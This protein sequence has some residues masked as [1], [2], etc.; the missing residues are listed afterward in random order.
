MATCEKTISFNVTDCT[1]SR[2][3]KL[4]V[5]ANKTVRQVR[6]QILESLVLEENEFDNEPVTWTLYRSDPEKVLSDTDVVRDVIKENQTV[7]PVRNIVAG[8]MRK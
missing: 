5:P 7:M 2:R 8:G 4:T 6:P 3:E 1:G